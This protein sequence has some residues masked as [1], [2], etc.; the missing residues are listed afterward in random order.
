M[1]AYQFADIAAQEMYRA[2]GR[3]LDLAPVLGTGRVRL[4]DG[5]YETL[6]YPG[7]VDGHPVLT[8]TAPW[9][10]EDVAPVRPSGPYLRHIAEGLVE[11]G[12]WDLAGIA[13]YLAACTGG[14]WTPGEIE[15]LLPR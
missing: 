3:D 2:P 14:D 11:S 5:R 7:D 1:T 4:G 9:S 15:A 10:R 12:A 6:L 13:V 8:F